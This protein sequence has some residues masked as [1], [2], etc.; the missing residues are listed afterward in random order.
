MKWHPTVSIPLLP[1]FGGVTDW[2]QEPR[3]R[4]PRRLKKKSVKRL[5]EKR[6]AKA[7]EEYRKSKANLDSAESSEENTGNAGGTVNVQGCSHKT[8]MNG[9][10]HPFNGT[11]GVVGL[12]PWIE[13]EEQVFEI[14]KCAEEDKV[15]FAAN[16]FEGHDDDYGIL[17]NNQNPKD[18]ARALDSKT[19]DS[20]RRLYRRTLQD[21]K[22]SK[23]RNSRYE[24]KLMVE[25]SLSG[26]E[27]S[28]F[29]I[30]MWL[31]GCL[32]LN[33]SL[34]LKSMS[35]PEANFRLTQEGEV[36]PKILEAQGEASKDYLKALAD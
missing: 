22:V 35:L 6:V 34:R 10:P 2:Y 11:K 9:K 7:I 17:L 25:E 20:D 18:G 36:I 27:K 26:G 3:I 8:F 1:E 16:T 24:W 5:V 21:I 23:R 12:R 13:K 4:P 19:L 33:R 32:L 28:I 29:L 30:R 31:K 15:M 14:C